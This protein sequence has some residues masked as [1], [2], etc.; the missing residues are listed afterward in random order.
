MKNPSHERIRVAVLGVRGIPEVQGGIERHYQELYPRLV[1][2]GCEVVIIA[3][4]GYVPPNP[5]I[6]LEL[7]S[8]EFASLGL[9]ECM[10]CRK[11]REDSFKDKISV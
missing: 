11:W 7:L 10:L 6:D 1:R 4:K 5:Y 9:A 3:R 2:L 8:V